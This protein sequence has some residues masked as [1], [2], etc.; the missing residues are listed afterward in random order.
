MENALSSSL[1]KLPEETACPPPSRWE[2][3]GLGGTDVRTVLSGNYFLALP[4]FSLPS[5]LW[6]PD[7]KG[8]EKTLQKWP[9][10]T[11]LKFSFSWCWFFFRAAGCR[12]WGGGE[13]ECGF[14]ENFPWASWKCSGNPLDELSPLGPRSAVWG[15]ISLPVHVGC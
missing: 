8:S 3:V 10:K 14:V 5:C 15:W 12:T 13:C 2:N 9:L 11:I 6:I 1:I 7:S 4:V